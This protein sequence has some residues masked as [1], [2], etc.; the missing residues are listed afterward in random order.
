M[1]RE[2]H[3]LASSLE[4]SACQRNGNVG[5]SGAFGA[6]RSSSKLKLRI[7]RS[8]VESRILELEKSVFFA[9]GKP[10]QGTCVQSFNQEA[11]HST[12]TM[13]VS[14]NS[15]G[16]RKLTAILILLALLLVLWAMQQFSSCLSPSRAK[17]FRAAYEL[18]WAWLSVD[19]VETSLTRALFGFFRR[20]TFDSL[21]DRVQAKEN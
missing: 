2:E 4:Q 1:C 5:A 21:R 7:S 16:F 10:A 18:K 12:M 6:A 13:H 17:T 15:S 3:A 11:P 14:R 19:G 20:L 9:A 8:N